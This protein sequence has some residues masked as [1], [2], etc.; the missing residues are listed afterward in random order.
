LLFIDGRKLGTLIPGS[1][2]Q[3]QFTAEEVERI[4]EAYRTFRRKGRP[5]EVPGFCK[6]A[7]VA[8]VA[9]HRFAL[10][11]GRYVGASVEDDADELFEER[12]PV[13]AARLEQQFAEAN[14]LIGVIRVRLNSVREAS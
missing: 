10:T 13:L 7:T 5:E 2:K 1:R 14:R 9:E 12:F 4:A 3:K 11:P 8:E 6:V